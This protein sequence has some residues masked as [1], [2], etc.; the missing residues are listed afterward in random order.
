MHSLAVRLFGWPSV[1]SDRLRQNS[2]VFEN[3]NTK[4]FGL[5]STYNLRVWT[6]PSLS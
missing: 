4:E 2:N 1:S 3:L 5:T 6:S